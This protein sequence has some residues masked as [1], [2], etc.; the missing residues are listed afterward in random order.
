ML[1]PSD[2]WIGFNPLIDLQTDIHLKYKICVWFLFMDGK[3][4][5]IQS[6]LDINHSTVG[7]YSLFKFPNTV[8]C[9]YQLRLIRGK[10]FFSDITVL[11]NNYENNIVG[12][13]TAYH[14]QRCTICVMLSNVDFEL[15]YGWKVICCC[16]INHFLSLS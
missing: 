16:G 13:A 6:I 2:F 3:Y 9:F 5:Q 12:N 14:F 7:Q 10:R 4:L 11:V 15:Y 8:H 1:A